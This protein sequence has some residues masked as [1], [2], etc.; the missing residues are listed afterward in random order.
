LKIIEIFK[1]NVQSDEDAANLI[2]LIHSSFQ[3]VKA[4]FDLDDCDKILR[5]VGSL[6]EIN[7]IPILF[8]QNGFQCEVIP[9]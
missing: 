4:N 3:E 9:E 7:T 2:H 5:I 6:E 8:I 1:T